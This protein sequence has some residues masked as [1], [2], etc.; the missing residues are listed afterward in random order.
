MN[1][2]ILA[3]WSTTYKLSYTKINFAMHTVLNL[4]TKQSTIPFQMQEN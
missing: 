1:F 4:H 2:Y 3:S